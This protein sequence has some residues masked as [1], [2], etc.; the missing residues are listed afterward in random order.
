MESGAR[1]GLLLT[2]IGLPGGMSGWQLAEA[3]RGRR[4]EVKRVFITGYAETHGQAGQ[5][6]GGL[7]AGVEIMTKPLSIGALADKVKGMVAAWP[8]LPHGVALASAS[9]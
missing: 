3:V 1:V 9:G 8:V 7:E 6:G 5:P 2:D 4:P